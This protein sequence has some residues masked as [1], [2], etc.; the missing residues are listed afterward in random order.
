MFIFIL[1]RQTPYSQTLAAIGPWTNYASIYS[2]INS[3]SRSTKYNVRT[4]FCRTSI[5]VGGA[6]QGGQSEVNAG[7]DCCASDLFL[8]TD[9]EF[10]MVNRCLYNDSYYRGTYSASDNKLILTF[11]QKVVNEIIDEQTNK[12]RNLAK[13]I[14]IVPIEFTISVCDNKV[15][16]QHATTKN[17]KNGSRY[18][19]DIEKQE[20]KEL[21][22]IE[23]WKLISE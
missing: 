4:K 10:G 20:L 9:K 22:G 21:K 12:K 15:R 3:D 19:F 18:T 7:C 23:A 16:F 5:S 11:K 6:F 13:K 17:L 2:N 14:K 1:V 8:I